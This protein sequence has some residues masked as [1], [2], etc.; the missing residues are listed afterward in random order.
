MDSNYLDIQKVR[1]PRTKGV[2]YLLRNDPHVTPFAFIEHSRQPGSRKLLET[3]ASTAQNSQ[4][5]KI[6][7]TTNHSPTLVPSYNLCGFADHGIEFTLTFPNPG[8]LDAPHGVRFSISDQT[9]EVAHAYVYLL[10]TPSGE[11]F[12]YLEDINVNKEHQRAGCGI[13]LLEAVIACAQEHAGSLICTSRHERKHIHN[14]YM[15]HG[16]LPTGREYR[17]NIL[18]E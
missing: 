3:F 8:T 12:A 13:R 10:R 6:I 4:C 15:R 1:L 7:G 11:P 9:K 18:D 2:L 5:Y 17:R 14:W 16:F